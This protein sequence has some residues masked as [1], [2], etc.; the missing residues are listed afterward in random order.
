MSN[1]DCRLSKIFRLEVLEIN[2][3]RLDEAFSRP[4]HSVIVPNI[5][6]P[7]SA[8]RLES[9]LHAALSEPC[10]A[11]MQLM[12]IIAIKEDQKTIHLKGSISAEEIKGMRYIGP[13]ERP[14]R[15]TPFPL[16]FKQA[17][18]ILRETN[19]KQDE[20]AKL[21]VSRMS[22]SGKC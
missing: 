13:M 5:F 8:L 21:N 10:P 16:Y 19:L 2:Q 7:K 17:S 1:A 6:R 9:F 14:Q 20:F 15:T 12:G 11:C 18:P 4:G 22:F 3:S